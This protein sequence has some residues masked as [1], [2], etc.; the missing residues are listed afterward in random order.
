M[1]QYPNLAG[2]ATDNLIEKIGGSGFQASY[3][4]WSRTMHLLREHAPGWLPETVPNGDGGLLHRAPVGAYLLIRFVH[5]DGRTTPSVPQSIMDNKNNSIA[6]ERITSRDVTDTQVRGIC[7]AAAL[8]FG[9]AYELWAK[10]PLESGYAEQEKPAKRDGQPTSGVWESMPIDDKND[11][12]AVARTCNEY[13][14]GD[15]VVGLVDYLERQHL[16]NDHKAALWTQLGGKVRTAI[17]KEHE[18]RRQAA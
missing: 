14:D 17:K 3:I 9:L 15:D 5:A 11:L 2:I 6:L 12:L 18:A 13:F 7:K 10:M 4:N 8:L 16:D 1:N